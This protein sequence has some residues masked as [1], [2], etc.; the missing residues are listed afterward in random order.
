MLDGIKLE[1]RCPYGDC[2]HITEARWDPNERSTWE[3]ECGDCRGVYEVEVTY[4]IT[5]SCTKLGDD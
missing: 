4:D 2:N 1:L 5:I 3:Q